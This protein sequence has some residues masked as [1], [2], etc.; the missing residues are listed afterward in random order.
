MKG[1]SDGRVKEGR[2]AD[3]KEVSGSWME[4]YRDK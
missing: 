2:E 4:G 1:E 3:R